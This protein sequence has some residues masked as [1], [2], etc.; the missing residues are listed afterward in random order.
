MDN[1]K[2]IGGWILPALAGLAGSILPGLLGSSDDGEGLGTHGQTMVV[3]GKGLSPHGVPPPP[4]VGRGMF[5]HGS[6]AKTPR[7]RP[8]GAVVHA[9]IPEIVEPEPVIEIAPVAP[10]P[11]GEGLK[12]K[13]DL[14][15][16]KAPILK[17]L[18]H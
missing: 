5:L 17:Q 14:V 7:R 10:K 18:R 15:P 16:Q 2:V 12:K 1:K 6:Q 11:E 3:P 9:P 13:S 8:M 4:P